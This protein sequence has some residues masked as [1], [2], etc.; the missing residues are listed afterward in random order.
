ML[1]RSVW[2]FDGKIKEIGCIIPIGKPGCDNRL[3]YELKQKGYYFCNVCHYVK[4]Y[5]KHESKIRNYFQKERVPR[6]YIMLE[7]MEKK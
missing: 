1:F 4:A 7:A 2:I 5:H 6:P 3:L